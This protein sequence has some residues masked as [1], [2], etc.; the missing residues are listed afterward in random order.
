MALDQF[1]PEILSPKIEQLLEKKMVFADFCNREYEGEIKSAG[2][3][4]RILELARP[5]VTTTTDGAPITISAFEELQSTA[6]TMQI[7]QQSYFAPVLHDIDERQSI[8]G[9]VEKIM[10]GGAYALADAMDSHVATVCATGV[11][12]NS[13]ATDIKTSTATI[14]PLIDAALAKLYVNNVAFNE[15]IELV[16]TPR[17]YMCIKAAMIATDT[18]NSA[19]LERGIA[20]KYGNVM[21]RVSNNIVTANAGAEDLLILRTRRAVAF[22]EQI[23]KLESGRKELGFG[24]FFKGLALYQAQLVQPKELIIIN[25]KYA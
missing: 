5:T 13:S 19:L 8:D 14:L 1:K 17:A 18:D 6:Q 24:T 16:V 10:K 11:K 2:D 23:N 20:A 21:I 7:N 4:V 25:A 22:V 9:V 3:S 15:E 12:D